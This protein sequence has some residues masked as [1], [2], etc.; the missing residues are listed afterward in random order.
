MDRGARSVNACIAPFDFSK[1]NMLMPKKPAL[2]LHLLNL[3]LS[4]IARET[5]PH[6]TSLLHFHSVLLFMIVKRGVPIGETRTK[7]GELSQRLL[8]SV[9]HTWLRVV[10]SS[11]TVDKVFTLSK[12]SNSI[13]LMW[14]GCWLLI[15]VDV[16]HFSLKPLLKDLI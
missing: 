1:R 2:L 12:M 7:V 11:Q 6:Q 8:Q 3:A 14:N 10:P 13:G 4:S 15:M 5:K 16:G 9:R